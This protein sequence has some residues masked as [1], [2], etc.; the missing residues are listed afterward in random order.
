MILYPEE[1]PVCCRTQCHGAM[2][3]NACVYVS[4]EGVVGLVWQGIY[5]SGDHGC[6]S[7]QG[8]CVA[9]AARLA[10]CHLPPGSNRQR[11]APDAPPRHSATPPRLS[12]HRSLS[13]VA[14][15]SVLSQIDADG[16]AQL[17]IIIFPECLVTL[18]EDDE[19]A[20]T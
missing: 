2:N 9:A 17:F 1:D 20:C 3:V 12:Q 7:L 19:Y 14:W 5:R 11:L 16:S 15:D 10:Q 4:V 13:C 8:A 18:P 6:G